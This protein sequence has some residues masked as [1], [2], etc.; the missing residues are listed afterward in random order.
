MFGRDPIFQSRLQQSQ[1]EVLDLDLGEEDLRTFLDRRGQAFKWVMPLAMRNLAIAQPR[2][3]ERYRLVRGG[4]WEPKAS[5]APG[6]YVMVR[7][8]T[9]NTLQAPARP[10][11]LRIVELKPSGVV[12]MEGSDAARC[13]E[14]IKNVAHCPLTI[15]DTKLYPGRYYRG[16]SV[17][18][19]RCGLRKDGAKMVLCEACQKGYHL[20]CM[21]VPLLHIPEGPWRC[22]KHEGT[23]YTQLITEI[24]GILLRSPMII[25]SW[26]K[27]T[28]GRP[29]CGEGS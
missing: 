9:K 15:L 12:L 5:F 3:K 24:G 16:P 13:E 19:G 21:D 2:D 23:Q 25:L 8:V 7:Q 17:H 29:L 1:E 14:Q 26:R 20:W 6:D 18:C 10:H 11:V 27:P 22:H 4:G 28:S